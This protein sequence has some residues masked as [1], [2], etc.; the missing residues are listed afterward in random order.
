ME[1][2][3]PLEAFCAINDL[4][5]RRVVLLDRATHNMSYKVARGIITSKIEIS[6]TERELAI[7]LRQQEAQE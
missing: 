6:R 2:K 7:S 4:E 5:R 1:S 3:D